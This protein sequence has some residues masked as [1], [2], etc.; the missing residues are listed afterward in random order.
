M[1]VQTLRKNPKALG[2]DARLK[3]RRREPC[4]ISVAA[5]ESDGQQ[6]TVNLVIP[7]QRNGLVC[8]VSFHF[9]SRV[10]RP[11]PPLSIRPSSQSVPAAQCRNALAHWAED[12]RGETYIQQQQRQRQLHCGR[13]DLCVAN[14]LAKPYHSPEVRWLYSPGL[15]RRA[16]DKKARKKPQSL[17]TPGAARERRDIYQVSMFPRSKATNR[18]TRHHVRRG[19]TPGKSFS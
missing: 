17:S 16:V 2:K 10:P 8:W 9:A 3:W 12:E 18:L 15:R 5:R 14:S 1:R 6:S 4:L 13:S 7:S 11:S 19:T